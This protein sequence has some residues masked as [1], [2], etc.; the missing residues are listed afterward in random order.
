M[1]ARGIVANESELARTFAGAVFESETTEGV[2]FRLLHELGEGG[3]G[4][5]FFAMR[6][7]P[8]GESPA[9]LKIVKPEIVATAGPTALLMV[10]KEA[11]ALGRLNEA[12]PPTPFVVRFLD[13]GTVVLRAMHNVEL[14]WIALEYVHGGAEGTTL[15][16]RVQY[17]VTHTRFAFDAARA[18]HIIECLTEGLAAIHD[19]GVVH[20][21][22]TPGN[23]LCCGFGATEVSK[24]ADF[25]IA[26]P[27]GIT[28]TFGGVLLGTPGYAAPEQ[29]FGGN[30]VGPWTDTFSF[31]CLVYFLLTG[32]Q[33]FDTS[34]FGQALMMVRD[35]K[36]R[37]VADVATLSP[38]IRDNPLLCR[39]LDQALARATVMTAAERPHDARSF[40]S[41][42]LPALRAAAGPRSQRASERLVASLAARPLAR[43]V[44][45]WTWTVRH[46]PG[47]ERLVRSVAWDGDGHCL[48]VTTD[49]LAYWDGTKWL[50]THVAEVD[51]NAALRSVSLVRPGQWLLS[52]ARG[53]LAVLAADRA[54]AVFR[55]PGDADFT[56]A[57]GD[58]DDLALV[59]SERAGD[60][61]L[62]HS[63][64]ARRFFRPTPLSA[65]R[66]ISSVARVDADR[67][68]IAGRTVQGN[69]FAAVYSALSFEP[70]FLLT[71]QT[72]ALTTCAGHPDRGFGVAAGRR[73][74]I[75]RLDG[76][77]SEAAVLDGAPDLASSAMDVQGRAWVGAAGALWSQGGEPR[78]HW[79]PAWRDS[80][81]HT[82]FV[83]LR[84][85][86]GVVTAMTVDG[87]V[88][89]GRVA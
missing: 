42:F 27:S 84:T 85:D 82:P 88:L 45:R 80:S 87:A 47:G 8:D 6:E 62:L 60:A 73:G 76:S 57:S 22:L 61:P 35:S 1:Y 28:V 56:L 59:V 33:Y 37:S 24:I 5:A 30:D 66:T 67:W 50:P 21:D 72:D 48:A 31:A 25:G 63:V 2:K 79:T 52:G 40:V 39:T 13:T 75:V 20:R 78:A 81:W 44:S 51:A 38:E 58:P 41:S 54:P 68:L 23:V 55:G 10:Q 64:A 19:V 36:R 65:A 17:S 34:N 53:L 89:E 86:V 46:P 70:T 16:Q 15:E 32:E 4:V 14:P 11:I 3:M 18:A 43:T 77:R 9:V 74:V 26:R 69:G 71:P 7:A 83:S 12:V 49:G 29:S